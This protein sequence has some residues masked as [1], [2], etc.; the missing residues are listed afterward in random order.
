MEEWRHENDLLAAV[1]PV[2]GG[3]AKE[4]R[5]GERASLLIIVNNKIH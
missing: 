4:G 5:R 2:S 1:G 3:L